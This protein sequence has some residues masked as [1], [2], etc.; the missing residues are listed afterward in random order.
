LYKHNFHGLT[1][2][3]IYSSNNILFRLS[4]YI[5]RKLKFNFT[6]R[7]I[8]ARKYDAIVHIGGSIFI[9]K[10]NWNKSKK[11]KTLSNSMPYFVLGANFGPYTDHLFYKYHY[12]LF[13]NYR[14]ICFRDNYSYQL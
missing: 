11:S 8:I 10:D 5:L 7:E 6:V 12:E 9:Q 13:K 1:N 4:N 14:D 2:I 3:T